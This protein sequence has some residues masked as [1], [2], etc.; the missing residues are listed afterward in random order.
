MADAITPIT[1]ACNPTDL[2]AKLHGESVTA[3]LKPF[4]KAAAKISAD[5]IAREAR[6]RLQRQLSGTSTGATLRGITVRSRGLGWAVLAERDPTPNL[7][8]WLEH[9]TQ[10]MKARP[11]FDS[12]AALETEAHR[13]RIAAAIV[14]GLS[15]YGLGDQG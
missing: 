13:E 11:Y 4:I 2:L 15:E 14:A 6:A 9:G 7:P 10:H 1:V 8:G 5:S 12:S 3:A